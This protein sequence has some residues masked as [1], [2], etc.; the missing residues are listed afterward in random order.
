MGLTVG[1]ARCHDHK[2]DPIPMADYYSLYGVFASSHEPGDKP[3]ISEAIDP[4]QRVAFKRERRR[5]EDNL[6]NYQ[7]EQYAYP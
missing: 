6:N 7:Q 1:C 2:Y 3:F 4:I 5:R